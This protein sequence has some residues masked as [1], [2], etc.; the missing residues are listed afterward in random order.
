M[1]KNSEGTLRPLFPVIFFFPVILWSAARRGRT[2]VRAYAGIRGH[3]RRA[4]MTPAIIRY[5]V[6]VA[7]TPERVA[8]RSI[9]ALVAA[10]LIRVRDDKAGAT[11]CAA[12]VEINKSVIA[13]RGVA[14]VHPVHPGLNLARVR[15]RPPVRPTD[16]LRSR[17]ARSRG[18]PAPEAWCRSHETLPG[19]LG[20]RTHTY[21]TPGKISKTSAK[22]APPRKR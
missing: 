18:D 1:G 15:A 21:A 12:S 10:A 11:Q 9:A 2:Y 14:R 22:G 17:D 8:G 13:S 5:Y 20:A 19:R 6:I 16:R 4:H 3:G 7:L